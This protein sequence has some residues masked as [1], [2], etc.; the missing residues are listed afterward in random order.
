MKLPE[1][2]KETNKGGGVPTA[3]IAAAEYLFHKIQSGEYEDKSEALLQRLRFDP[4]IYAVWKV[5][6]R[7]RKNG[8]FVYA[9]RMEGLNPL[10]IPIKGLIERSRILTRFGDRESLVEKRR[11]EKRLAEYR[12]LRKKARRFTSKL[13]PIQRQGLACS[14]LF[15]IAF[16]L[17]LKAESVLNASDLQIS[18]ALMDFAGIAPPTGASR[19]SEFE[20]ASEALKSIDAKQ[21][22][23]AFTTSDLEVAV[24][25]LQSTADELER[26]ARRS[27][28]LLRGA[29]V[30]VEGTTT[31]LRQK[32]KCFL[33]LK[34][35]KLHVDRH[36]GDNQLRAFA[37]KLDETI[38]N[39]FG[40]SMYG[41][42]AR[43]GA[44]RAECYL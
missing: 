43:D 41:T 38:M 34:G 17:G 10:S 1:H 13:S 9:A 39:L 31:A 25:Y 7:R 3:V 8:S 16:E 2:T 27:S 36:R 18:K 21:P 35:N 30:G 40:S 44:C 28:L 5:L 6:L 14:Y 15:V 42:A 4:R 19:S 37:I 23:T 24:S 12:L 32:A 11:L 20:I 29:K 33:A 22:Q 26:L